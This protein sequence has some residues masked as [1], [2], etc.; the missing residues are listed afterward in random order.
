[1]YAKFKALAQK[2]TQLIPQFTRK[3]HDMLI[4]LEEYG[5]TFLDWQ[6]IDMYL[7]AIDRDLR[8]K[9]EHTEDV[10]SLTI[11]Q[12]TKLA[13]K[14]EKK[15]KKKAKSTL[16]A[17]TADL[18]ISEA[19][20]LD[21]QFSVGSAVEHAKML[22][23]LAVSH[24]QWDMHQCLNYIKQKSEGPPQHKNTWQKARGRG[25]G[26]RGR[27]RRGERPR[28]RGRYR[29]YRGG[30]NYANNSAPKGKLAKASQFQTNYSTTAWD[31]RLKARANNY[32]PSEFPA[33]YE[34][35]NLCVVVQG[36]STVQQPYCILC[37]T[38]ASKKK[39]G[40]T[41]GGCHVNKQKNRFKALSD[42]H[43]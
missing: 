36:G 37:N 4:K 1:M 16:G 25:R 14:L 21:S 17:L 15:A 28:G 42:E 38:L 23:S 35:D 20:A 32:A 3:W 31:R 33:L 18:N 39:G 40:H 24:P 27:G 11:E 29:G 43:D 6:G 30:Q 19:N 41:A 7:I 2:S 12:I 13:T 10:K 8:I 5:M 9:I 22:A 26:G 34:L